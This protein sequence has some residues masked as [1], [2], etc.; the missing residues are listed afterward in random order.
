[1][2]RNKSFP[3]LTSDGRWKFHTHSGA[4]R[5]KIVH[6]RGSGNHENK[7]REPILLSGKIACAPFSCGSSWEQA[8]VFVQ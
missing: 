5:R 1:M 4:L 6:G 8:T 7:S 2:A 3:E